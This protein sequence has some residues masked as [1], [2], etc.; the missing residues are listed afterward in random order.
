MSLI[1]RNKRSKE[2]PV[3]PLSELQRDAQER[4]ERVGRVNAVEAEEARAQQE[5]QDN[6]ARAFEQQQ[7]DKK[8]REEEQAKQN[9]IAEKERLKLVAQN[10]ADAKAQA[11][12]EQDSYDLSQ[13]YRNATSE[14]REAMNRRYVEESVQLAEKNRLWTQEQYEAQLAKEAQEQEK[15]HQDLLKRDREHRAALDRLAKED[16]ERAAEQVYANGNLPCEICGQPVRIGVPHHMSSDFRTRCVR[17]IAATLAAGI[18]SPEYADQ[19]RRER[20][21]IATAK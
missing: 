2:E 18:I 12:R 3:E 20:S 1:H 4:T 10:N 6:A 11:K 14:E 7:A 21:A 13:A 5:L 17:D 8:R 16:A 9:V 19:L 15:A